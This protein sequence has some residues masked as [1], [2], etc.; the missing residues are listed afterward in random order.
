MPVASTSPGFDNQTCHWILQDVWGLWGGG[1]E[2]S[3][4]IENRY[5]RIAF[6]VVTK[7]GESLRPGQRF[8]PVWY[9]VQCTAGAHR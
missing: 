5:F 2:K 6:P 7:Q 8:L 3:H 9:L 1:G 4:P